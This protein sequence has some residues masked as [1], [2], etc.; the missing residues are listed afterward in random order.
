MKLQKIAMGITAFSALFLC[1]FHAGA[2]TKEPFRIRNIIQQQVNA[3]N[4]GPGSGDLGGGHP[5]TLYRSWL[6]IE[7][8]FESVPDWSDDVQL[9]FYLLIGAGR[10]RRLL[11]GDVTHVN[12][13]RGPQHYSAMFVHPNAL[14]RYGPGKVEVV[15]VQVFHQNRLV[16]QLSN[17]DTQATRT[18]WWEK[19]PPNRELLNPLLTP[20]SVIA[21]ERY[22]AVKPQ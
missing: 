22:E 8:Q 9:K 6:R 3:P 14:Q 16:D 10:E 12:V 15:T 2:Q 1:S 19:F 21:S 5:A 17:P 13:A 11:V 4:Y 7:A 20:W 18:S